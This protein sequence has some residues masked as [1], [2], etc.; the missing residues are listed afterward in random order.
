MHSRDDDNPQW[1]AKDFAAART[2]DDIP[3][4]ILAAF[5]KSRGRPKGQTKVPVSLRLDTDLVETLRAYGPGWQS[6]VNRLLRD[7]VLGDA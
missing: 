6:R 3:A 1:S 4:A 7:A 2:G 5:P